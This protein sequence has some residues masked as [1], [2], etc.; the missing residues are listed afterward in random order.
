[1][2]VSSAPQ[3]RQTFRKSERLCSRKIIQELSKKARNIQVQAFR[4]S[5]LESTLPENVPAQVVFSVP[6]RNFRHA[7]DRNRIKRRMREAYRKNKS[8]IYPL[9]S[10][11]RKQFALL[12]VYTGSEI[13]TF[14]R[15]EEN[16]LNALNRFAQD[17]QKY[18]S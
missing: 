1:M 10:L 13:P 6:K 12:I 11:S 17:I 3:Q 2:S 14:A 15:T 18:C 4:L 8:V 16:I 5:W 7:V 9:I